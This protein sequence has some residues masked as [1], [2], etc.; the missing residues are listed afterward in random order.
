M[1]EKRKVCIPLKNLEI[2]FKKDTQSDETSLIKYTSF[3][4]LNP[5][6]NYLALLKIQDYQER[7]LNKYKY[8]LS[9]E[10]AKK[11]KCFQD[12]DEIDLIKGINEKLD[13]LFFKGEKIKKIESLSKAKLLDFFLYLLLLKC[14]KEDFEKI[15][16]KIN[17]LRLDIDLIFKSPINLGN[18]ELRYY[19]YYELFIEYF[20]ITEEKEKEIKS[21]KNKINDKSPKLD[22]FPTVDKNCTEYSDVDLSDFNIRKQSLCDFLGINVNDDIVLAEDIQ[23]E[24]I[25]E[26]IIE[27]NE[28]LESKKE[29]KNEDNKDKDS[30]YKKLT[31]NIGIKDKNYRLFINKLYYFIYF[32]ETIF[33]IFFDSKNDEEILEKL[34]YFYFYMILTI[35]STK[36]YDKEFIDTFHLKNTELDKR[37]M[38]IYDEQIQSLLGGDY[39]KIVFRKIPQPLLF[40]ENIENPF[41][42]N[43]FYFP[44]PQLMHK[45]FIE[46][47]EDIYKEFK[48][49]LKSI[50]QS[51]LLKDI[52]YLS[53]E[54][55]DFE[56][57][58]KNDDILNEMFENTHYIPCN[59]QNLYGYTQKNLVSIFIPVSFEDTNTTSIK[60]NINFLK[61][62]LLNFEE[63][64][65]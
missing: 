4:D 44:F 59:S 31:R 55:K 49:F 19:F 54:F 35:K 9:Y 7:Y 16:E 38:E 15:T 50:Y 41:I 52:Y 46:Y 57:P 18:N 39:D 3:F 51:K 11:L 48:I 17:S 2:D 63:R 21:K 62:L 61:F 1:T 36:P 32:Q 22:Y 27:L 34:K 64:Y 53:T 65:Y 20:S 58:F 43:Y 5:D 30:S 23:N 24:K 10:D 28:D 47:D 45:S 40:F 37:R 13:N 25:K 29:N 8:T 6:A 60:K 33:S 26:N 14:T 42:N 12:V 56:Y